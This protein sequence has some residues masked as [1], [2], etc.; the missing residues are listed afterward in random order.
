M[1]KLP[2][3][4]SLIYSIMSFGQT[5]QSYPID[6]CV[7]DF[8]LNTTDN[9]TRIGST[10]LDIAYSGDANMP[11]LPYYNL[12]LLI[13]KNVTVTD[14]TINNTGSQFVGK[15]ILPSNTSA[16]IST[17]PFERKLA[18]KYDS[19]KKYPTST[20]PYFRQSTIDGYQ[21]LYVSVCPFEYN[22]KTCDLYLKTGLSLKYK[23]VARKYDTND[24]IGHN[25]HDLVLNIV[26]NK[27]D[28]D[29][30]YPNTKT[31]I[32]EHLYGDYLII[33]ADSL[34]H[35][36]EPLAETKGY[37]GLTT[38]IVSVEDII[39]Q[40]SS[41]NYNSLDTV[42]KI[43]Y[44]IQNRYYNSNLGYVLLAGDCDIIPTRYCYGN[45]KNETEMVPTD[46]YYA[47]VSHD[48]EFDTQWDYNRNH[49]YGEPGDRMDLGADLIVSRLPVSNRAEI[50]AYLSKRLKYELDEQYNNDSYNKMLFAGRVIAI[51]D[52]ISDAQQ[53]GTQIGDTIQNYYNADISYLYDTY[54]NIGNIEFSASTLQEQLQ[55]EN[56]FVQ[57]DTHGEPSKLL[58]G[59][60]IH[61]YLNPDEFY[62]S[63]SVMNVN[64]AG[65][66]IITS[67]ACF[68]ND[69]DAE[70]SLGKTFLLK[71]DNGTLFFI[72]NSR[73]GIAYDNDGRIIE[74][75]IYTRMYRYLFRNQI[76]NIAECLFHAKN[77][78]CNPDENTFNWLLYTMNTIGDPEFSPYLQKPGKFNADIEIVSDHI[79]V[80]TGQEGCSIYQFGEEDGGWS[81]IDDFDDNYHAPR[82]YINSINFVIYKLGW[83][84]F[85]LKRDFCQNLYIQDIHGVSLAAKGQNIEIGSNVV[86]VENQN[87]DFH[88]G[89]V[90]VNV[91]KSFNLEVGHELTITNDFYVEI[92][93]ELN[94]T[95]KY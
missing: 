26:E 94:I 6:I 22:A 72:G 15:F 20:K 81:N 51:I 58:T 90:T 87:D 33:T 41:S 30:M 77:H 84:P 57:I 38:K 40:Y 69:Y 45:I 78:F 89:S 92:G 79:G 37:K 14:V 43:K 88:N 35:A 54:S 64:S 36:L 42:A 59:K 52:G 4:L 93:G 49:I 9:F 24:S 67:L 25:M 61:Y 46:W 17:E 1:R 10:K 76:S 23:T 63:D 85:L 91:G 31:A 53:F 74:P 11:E 82:M 18:L 56:A 80:T 5:S 73:E 66:T 3:I 7:E 62:T 48:S 55:N 75:K 70:N 28:M 60:D 44:Y 2:F 39:Q 47:C 16:W 32:Y 71:S 21:V 13:P 68:S 12:R 8:E 83:I 27:G 86:N 65:N 29:L 50:E 19:D 34:K 95:P